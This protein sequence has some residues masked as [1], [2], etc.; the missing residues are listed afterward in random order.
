MLA[1]KNSNIALKL[2]ANNLQT[3][4]R[5]LVAGA[6]KRHFSYDMREIAKMNA[7]LQR[8]INILKLFTEEKE[9]NYEATQ[10]TYDSA[11]GEVT[12]HE[13]EK[14]G[15]KIINNYDEYEQSKKDLYSELGLESD[16]LPGENA[17]EEKIKQGFIDLEMNGH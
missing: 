10:M 17:D 13:K 5:A 1:V 3:S 2:C 11:T 7:L 16:G 9:W 8:K 15:K 6:P 14:R 4:S 12:I